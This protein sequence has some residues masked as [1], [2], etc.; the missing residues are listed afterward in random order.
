MSATALLKAFGVGSGLTVAALVGH[1]LVREPPA[2]YEPAVES[3]AV[4]TVPVPAASVFPP[5]MAA[6]L[7]SAEPVSPVDANVIMKSKPSP[8]VE[9]EEAAY[10]ARWESAWVARARAELRAGRP[11]DAL[12]TLAEI[13]GRVSGG[14]LGQE[15]EALT[16]E[17]LAASGQRSAAS[18][19]AI[20][21]V[22]RFPN[23]PHA[24]RV[25]DFVSP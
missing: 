6:P 12:R 19:R 10:G 24:S 5:V 20:A 23:S 21:F 3:V 15:R 9:P 1:E 13:Q 14:V 18:Q 4:V 7:A 25:R 17:A 11:A 16:I 8:G 22:E 2:A